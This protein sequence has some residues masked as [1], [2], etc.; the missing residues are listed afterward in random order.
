MTVI[1]FPTTCSVCGSE[2]EP[3]GIFYKH[4][5]H[6]FVCENCPEFADGGISPVSLNAHSDFCKDKENC[7][8]L[9]KLKDHPCG[10]CFGAFHAG[11]RKMVEKVKSIV[12]RIKKKEDY[13]TAKVLNMLFGSLFE[14]YEEQK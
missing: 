13:H 14:R 6:G 7:G 11:E 3:E 10:I 1:E 4:P 5:K 12:D 9:D 2:I 8:W